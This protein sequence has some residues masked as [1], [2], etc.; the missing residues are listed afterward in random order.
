LEGHSV[1]PFCPHVSSSTREQILIKFD[2]GGSKSKAV[3]GIFNF[4]LY[5]S[6]I[7]HSSDTREKMGVQWD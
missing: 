7:L 1:Y 2:M 6:N 5:Q 3:V 4:G